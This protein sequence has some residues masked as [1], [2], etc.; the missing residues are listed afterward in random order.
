MLNE[1][2]ESYFYFTGPQ[3]LDK[4]I[5]TLEGL[6]RGITIDAQ[7]NPKESAALTAWLG[8]H[9]EFRDRHPFNEVV[10]TLHA[11]LRDGMIDAEEQSDLLWLCGK[12]GTE[13]RYYSEVCS[14]MQR[15]QGVLGGISADGVISEDELRG[16]RNWLSD[17][18]HLRT[19]WPF[20]EIDSLLTAVLRDGQIDPQ[21]HS[22]LLRFFK[23]FGAR[24]GHRAIDLC[25]DEAEE[26]AVITGICA[27]CP[28][29]VF[30]GRKFCF[31]GTSKRCSR[32]EI[33]DY[34]NR[35]GSNFS[36]TLV[37]TVDYLVIGGNGNPCWAYS[38][39]GRKVEQ[40][41]KLR[42]EGSRLLLV[43][44]NDFWDAVEDAMA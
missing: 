11:V 37:K 24:P 41:I 40:A 38:C 14:D 34:V 8:E 9:H 10:G 22:M 4:A 28:E 33:A 3:R 18:E 30:D 29:I 44:E 42:R 19:C 36:K 5:H 17:H 23:E 21:E 31:T 43:H 13:N 39:Y 25:E 15:L 20:D 27:V 26:P 16:L 32:D 12:F 7:V 6:L 2:N 35:L 1:D